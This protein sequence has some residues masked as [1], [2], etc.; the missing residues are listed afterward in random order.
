MKKVLK[1]TT[2]LILLFL[3]TT[4]AYGDDNT[5]EFD[6]SSSAVMN[7]R[8]LS[9]Y[10]ENDEPKTIIIK[11]GSTLPIERVLWI[12]DNTKFIAKDVTI[13]QT[14][15]AKP[16][17]Q[18][19][20]DNGEYNSIKNVEIIGGTYKVAG[21]VL[22]PSVFRFAHGND[23]LIKDATI[24]TN[25]QSHGISFIA[26]KNSTIDG[27]KVIASNNSTKNSKSLE[28]AVQLDIATQKTAPSIAEYGSEYVKGQ[29]CE[30]ITIKN[31]TIS[32][33]RGLCA[34]KTDSH[35]NNFH[36]NIKVINNKIVGTSA[37]AAALHNVVGITATNNTITTINKRYKE[38][39]SIGLNI[40]SFGKASYTSKYKNTISNNTI[41][42]GRQGL[43]IFAY[44][45]SSYGETVVT[46]NKLYSKVSKSNA[47]SVRTCKKIVDKNNKCYKG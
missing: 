45:G 22:K 17:F 9:N 13:I 36:K 21:N 40:A 44:K 38:P 3:S 4:F 35:L 33:S 10:L 26:V 23:I 29:T 34:N 16:I 41:K 8:I 7:G 42:G 5:F 37:E 27:C 30:N 24:E 19:N 6:P 32:G 46:N 20:C 43:F 11:P 28:E 31:S 1:I 25:Y 47:K 14:N 39:Y 12:N 2:V 15:K 18:N